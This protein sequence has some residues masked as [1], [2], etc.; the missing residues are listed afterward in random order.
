MC[1]REDFARDPVFELFWF[2]QNLDLPDTN[3]AIFPASMSYR[4]SSFGWQFA[5][6]VGGSEEQGIGHRNVPGQPN[7]CDM[8]KSGN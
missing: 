5:M 6:V 3:D 2:S 1:F 4:S 8:S 7:L